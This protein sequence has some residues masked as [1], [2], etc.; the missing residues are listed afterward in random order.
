MNDARP[1]ATVCLESSVEQ[2][3]AQV[4]RASLS[5]TDWLATLQR[6][7]LVRVRNGDI[8]MPPAMVTNDTPCYVFTGKLKFHRRHGWQ[9][10]RQSS[11]VYRMKLRLVRDEDEFT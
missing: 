2:P 1:R 7:D 11:C 8:V 6:G 10:A 4:T 9:V 3:G 5:H